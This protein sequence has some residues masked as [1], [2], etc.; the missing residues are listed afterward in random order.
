LEFLYVTQWFFEMPGH[1][2]HIVLRNIPRQ[3]LDKLIG[4]RY[5]VV[6]QLAP[7]RSEPDF[8]RP[9]VINSRTADHNAIAFHL[10]D[11]STGCRLISAGEVSNSANPAAIQAS[12]HAENLPAANG[13]SMFAQ[14]TNPVLV[15]PAR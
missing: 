13:K 5:Q 15:N 4:H 7:L 6:K 9:A 3:F 10:I 14:F 12:Q 11:H 1:I 2:P 8:H